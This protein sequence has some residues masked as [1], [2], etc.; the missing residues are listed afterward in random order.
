MPRNNSEDQPKKS[1][2]EV[3][4]NK[5]RSAH[6]KED[7]SAFSPT[8]QIRSD[9]ASKVYKAKLSA[10]FDGEG[11]P[12]EMIR[13]KLSN[14]QDISE[15]GKERLEAMK[16][17]KNASNSNAI[18]AA[19]YSYLTRWELPLDYDLLSQ[20]LNCDNDELIEKT[21]DIL[22]KM[23]SDRRIPKSVQLLEQRLRRVKTLTEDPNIQKKAGTLIRDLRL[24]KDG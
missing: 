18:E 22:E 24:F 6:R 13:E 23:L 3:D 5:D 20:A 2:R 10:F 17:I 9:S 15:E 1:W 19:F 8:K 11:K 16:K 21:L 12:P 14:I 7:H 4:K